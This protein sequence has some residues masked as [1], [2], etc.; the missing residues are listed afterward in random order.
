M[1]DE[2]QTCGKGLAEHAAMP[3]KLAA[4]VAAM[5]EV[6]DLHKDAL[7]PG[8][9]NA[10]Q[11]RAAY[12]RLVGEFREIAARLRETAAHMAG[13]RDLPMGRHD[14]QALGDQRNVE[15]FMAYI[16]RERELVDLLTAAIARDEEM[17][18]E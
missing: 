6:L 18:R 9:A 12:V 13:Y 8:D 3:A 10:M 17:I 2:E 14:E 15:A 5:A 1:N 11:E 4:L 7:D 16:A